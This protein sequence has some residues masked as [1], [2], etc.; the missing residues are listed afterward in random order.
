MYFQRFY[1]TPLAQASYIIGCQRTGEAVVVDPIRD[2]QQ[3][4]DAA[5]HEGLRITHVTETHIHADFVSGAREL[6]QRTDARL[7]LS[8]EGGDDWQYAYAEQEGAQLLADGDHFHVGNIRLDV[9]HT[10]GHTPEHLSFMVTDVPAHAGPWGILT[11]DFVFVGDVGRPDLLERAAGM[12]GT[13]EAGARA[14]FRSLERFRAL[15]DHLQ[16]W[17]GHGAGSACGKAI[18]AVAST[19]VGYEKLANWGL[20]TTDETEFVRFVLEGQ[21]E[22]PRYFRE[23]KR[24]NRE[25]PRI[26]GERRPPARLPDDALDDLLRSGAVVLD[27]RRAAEFAGCHVPGTLNIPLDDG[28]ATWAG[29]LLPY[30]REVYLI[31]DDARMVSKAVR[32]LATIGLDR[33]GGYLGTDALGGW[34]RSGHALQRIAQAT[35]REVAAMLAHGAVVIDVRGRTEWEAGRLPGARN[36]PLGYLAEQMGDLPT[37]R[38]IIVQCQTGRRSAIGASLLQAHGRTNVVNMTGGYAGWTA[39]DL[40][41]ACGRA[42]GRADPVVPARS[43]APA[44]A[45]ILPVG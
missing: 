4:L 41:V 9:L 22:P 7:L 18:G 24:I 17:P 8:R 37:D 3:Y 40:P 34:S 42:S 26:L 29:W 6:A 35:P 31:A 12:K 16:V 5:T 43:H 36:V 2:V 44:P 21:P 38:P 45:H 25:G 11:G 14:L 20:T 27:T 13:M 15:P 10:P 33:V 1:D 32:D 39:A 19:T 30:D 28:F 23:M